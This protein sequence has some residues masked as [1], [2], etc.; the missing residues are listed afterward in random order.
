M[1][2]P[3]AALLLIDVQK[4]FDDPVWGHRNNPEA[5]HRIAELLS[6]WRKASQPVIHIQ[7]LSVLPHSSL[8]PNHP[9]CAFK[10]EAQPEEGEVIFQ[11]SVNSAFIGT[12]LEVHLRER[13]IQKLIIVGLTTDHCVS[14]TTRM[15]GNLGFEVNVVEDAVATFDREFRG[16]HY[17]AQ[18]IHETALASLDGEFAKVL[19]AADLLL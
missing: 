9:G 3:C 1:T 16:K 8:H 2:E 17:P 10:P 19:A 18:L 13:G 12:D 15:A 7:H 4:A 14:T 11:K 6:F 5:E